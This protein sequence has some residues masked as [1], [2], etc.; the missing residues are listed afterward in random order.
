MAQTLVK[1]AGA[2]DFLGD[3]DDLD[4]IFEDLGKIEIFEDR[5]NK[6]PKP[7]EY[8]MPE[9][10]YRRKIKARN[11]DHIKQINNLLTN[12]SDVIDTYNE[13]HDMTVAVVGSSLHKKNYNDIDIVSVGITDHNDLNTL[14]NRMS[15]FLDAG[16]NTSQSQKYAFYLGYPISEFINPKS[17]IHY[18]IDRSGKSFSEWHKMMVDK[19][20]KYCL[21]KLRKSTSEK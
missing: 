19:K 1:M 5:S 20:E 14:Y 2:S 3:P 17:I 8:A 16:T 4:S 11:P 7:E 13:Y 15:V 18:L 9:K 12:I 10:S 6:Y 21:L